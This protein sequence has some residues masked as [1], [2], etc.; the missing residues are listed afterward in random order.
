MTPES[1]RFTLKCSVSER[2][3]DGS[4]FIDASVDVWHDR[5]YVTTVSIIDNIGFQI[6]VITDRASVESFTVAAIASLKT[7]LDAIIKEAMRK[8]DYHYPADYGRRVVS[9]NPHAAR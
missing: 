6:A 1:L 9:Q 2:Q 7:C 4:A 8:G 5:E 3:G